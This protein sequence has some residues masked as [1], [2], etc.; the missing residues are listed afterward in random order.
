MRLL[1]QRIAM[2]GLLTALVL[3]VMGFVYAELAVMFLAGNEVPRAEPVENANRSRTEDAALSHSLRVRVPVMMALFGFAFVALG[4]L[5]LYAWRGNPP[6][7]VKPTRERQAD[8]A[9][10]LLEELL[11]QADA[12]MASSTSVPVREDA[13][14]Q[15][16]SERKTAAS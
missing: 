6:V 9:E 8:P 1:L 5:L 12:A 3:A 16:D 2:N 15:T 14:Q 10:K 13:S 7:D 11:A 4:E